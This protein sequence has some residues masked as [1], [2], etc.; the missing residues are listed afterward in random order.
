MS[1]KRLDDQIADMLAA[2][3]AIVEATG[4]KPGKGT[5]PCPLCETGTLFYSVASRRAVMARCTTPGCVWFMS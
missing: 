2:V 5:I 4:G 3:A 1:D